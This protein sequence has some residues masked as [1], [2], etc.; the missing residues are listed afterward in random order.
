MGKHRDVCDPK[1]TKLVKLIVRH[2]GVD[3]KR[4]QSGINLVLSPRADERESSSLR[5]GVHG[6][7]EDEE[8]KVNKVQGIVKQILISS[9]SF[10]AT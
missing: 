5:S 8:E 4:E 2:P 3:E 6:G 7:E 9:R 1:I 10:R